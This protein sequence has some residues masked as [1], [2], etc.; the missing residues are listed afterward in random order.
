MENKADGKM[1]A[2][3][4][5]G[6]SGLGIENLKYVEDKPIPKPGKGEL[7]IKVHAAGLNP[8]DYKVCEKQQ[9][10]YPYVF[11]VDV[12]G[13]ID[14][15][16]QEE[17]K[18]ATEEMTSSG[19]KKIKWKKGDRVYYHNSIYNPHGGFAEYAIVPAHVVANVPEDVSFVDA[20]AI[21]CAGYTAYQALF[22][23]MHVATGESILITGGAGGVGIF[24]IQLAASVGMS[25]IITTCSAANFDFVR[26]LGATDVIDYN[27]EKDIAGKVKQLC[28]STGGVHCILD[29]VSSESATALVP[30]L[31]FMGRLA[32]I[33]GLATISNDYFWHGISN[34]SVALGGCHFKPEYRKEQKKLAEMGREF[35]LRL[36][37][38]LKPMI[39]ETITLQEIPKGLEKLKQRHARGK[40][41]VK[42]V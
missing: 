30:A 21:P 20:A 7:R 18:A 33:A 28:A 25:P 40:I 14:A 6:V 27:Q 17:E 41:V 38:G 10:V 4:A 32:T 36:R 23:K 2:C 29:T 9:A 37:R 1:K 35:I 3:I 31:T 11:G 34:D 42:I 16:G 15:V 8:I 13:T 19:G 24:A 39:T 26:S 22:V 5:D 12:A